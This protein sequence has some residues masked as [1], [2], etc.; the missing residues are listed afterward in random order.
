MKEMTE[1]QTVNEITQ[2]L[3]DVLERM[4]H[5]EPRCVAIK[6]M[7]YFIQDLDNIAIE[8]KHKFCY[9]YR[10]MS[11]RLKHELVEL[12]LKLL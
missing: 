9:V 8:G 3:H 4:V 11:T 5:T 2:M 7:A 6:D 12:V 10:N 1:Q